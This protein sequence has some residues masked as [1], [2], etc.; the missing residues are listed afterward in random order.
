MSFF[1]NRL[2]KTN[3]NKHM[4]MK[5]ANDVLMICWMNSLVV[6]YEFLIM[7]FYYKLWTWVN[8]ISLI[9]SHSSFKLF[10]N[11]IRIW[12]KTL[13]NVIKIF[14]HVRL[15]YILINFLLCHS[16][17]RWRCVWGWQ[18]GPVCTA[19]GFDG[20]FHRIRTSVF[21]GR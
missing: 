18:G 14:H 10:I 3:I 6:W 20:P 15:L 7:R 8:I 19:H 13:S 9:N 16:R 17:S 1:L 21:W 2:G 11:K 12:K 5:H 4:L